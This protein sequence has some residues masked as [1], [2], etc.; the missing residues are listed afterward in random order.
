MT[1]EE[2]SSGTIM[3]DLYCDESYM[4]F[5]Y[6]GDL[7][8]VRMMPFGVADFS[9]GRG[10]PELLRL[11]MKHFESIGFLFDLQHILV[12]GDFGV[13]PQ[14]SEFFVDDKMFPVR[15]CFANVE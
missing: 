5:Y 7:I 11:V 8:Y 1:E 14:I 6:A 3:L 4:I 2:L 9:E 13:I 10:L 15:C 12:L